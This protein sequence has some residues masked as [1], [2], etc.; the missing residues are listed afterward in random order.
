[1]AYLAPDRTR[2]QLRRRNRRSRDG[3][4]QEQ[5][6]SAVHRPGFLVFLKVRSVV[7]QKIFL[8]L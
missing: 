1:V 2:S 7:K 4:D 5:V 6:K 3:R 8:R